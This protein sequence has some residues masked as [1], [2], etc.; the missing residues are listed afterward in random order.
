M[1]YRY[2]PGMPTLADHLKSLDDALRTID[3]VKSKLA[4]LSAGL[5]EGVE[6]I[7]TYDRSTLIRRAVDTLNS[8]LVEEFVVV[9]LVCA[10][11]L[12]VVIP[13]SPM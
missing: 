2:I 3:G 1:M 11:F 5:P 4:E 13:H 12:L 6:I 8:R 10:L 7:E 9:A